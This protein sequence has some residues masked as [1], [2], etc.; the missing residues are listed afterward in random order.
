MLVVWIQP[1]PVLPILLFSRAP[2][3]I[4]HRQMLYSHSVMAVPH[5]PTSEPPGK[6]LLWLWAADRTA[7]FFFVAARGS[8]AVAA[9]VVPNTAVGRGAA[10]SGSAGSV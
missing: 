2:P 4:S 3:D 1:V 8:G 5:M 9:E 6:E 7:V 10:V